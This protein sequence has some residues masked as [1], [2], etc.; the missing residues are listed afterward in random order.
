[1]LQASAS[2]SQALNN[3][4]HC[5]L[6]AASFVETFKNIEKINPAGSFVCINLDTGHSLPFPTKGGEFI[7]GTTNFNS[8]IRKLS[9]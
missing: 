3:S 8:V 4:K 1:M 6:V 9:L 2:I 7:K 5:A